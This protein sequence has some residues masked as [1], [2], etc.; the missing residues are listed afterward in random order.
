MN[1]SMGTVVDPSEPL[2]SRDVSVRDKEMFDGR[3]TGVAPGYDRVTGVVQNPR[4]HVDHV[5]RVGT[6]IVSSTEERKRKSLEDKG[7]SS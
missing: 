1:G 2:M 5:R 4:L 7:A 3:G 6:L